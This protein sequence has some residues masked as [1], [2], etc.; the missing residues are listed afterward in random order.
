MHGEKFRHFEA[1]GGWKGLTY[2]VSLVKYTCNNTCL[3]LH[4]PGLM[5][6][7]QSLL[8]ESLKDAWVEVKSGDIYL[9]WKD[10]GL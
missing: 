2:Q 3:A 4:N 6:G 10:G 5:K 7:T 9:L 1:I 8:R